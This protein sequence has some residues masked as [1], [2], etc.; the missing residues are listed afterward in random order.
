M[1]LHTFLHFD[2]L[3]LLQVILPIPH[4]PGKGKKKNKIKTENL[5]EKQ[6]RGA[7]WRQRESWREYQKSNK[8]L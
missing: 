2:F 1:V 5:S 7:F 3:K 8:P 4:P 6:K